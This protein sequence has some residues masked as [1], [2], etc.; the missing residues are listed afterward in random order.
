MASRE[1]DMIKLQRFGLL[2]FLI[3]VTSYYAVL[4]YK[5]LQIGHPITQDEPGFIEL[6]AAGSSYTHEGVLNSGNVY[7]PGYPLWARPF[8]AIFDNPYIAHRWA[9]TVA[10][11]VLLGFLMWVLLREGVGGI[12]T[13]AAAA[14]VY[15]LNVSS[16]SLSASGDLL[17]AAL[18]FAALTV[19]RRGTWPALVLGIVF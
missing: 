8:T 1:L 14:I 11:F 6:T 9:S 7:G 2:A 16:H 19:S 4:H 10:L 3:A 18:Y 17:G 12:E 15:I 5:V 13:A